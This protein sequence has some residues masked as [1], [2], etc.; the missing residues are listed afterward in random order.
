MV[1]FKATK[2]KPLNRS[3]NNQGCF[4]M[5][6]DQMIENLSMLGTFV[7]S[8]LN[9]EKHP[10]FTE[11]EKNNPWFILPFI[12]NALKNILSYL[13]SE[14]LNSW[15]QHYNFSQNPRRIG[16]VLAGNIPLVGLHD[17]ICVLCSG[18][19]AILQISH[20]DRIL[21]PFLINKLTEINPSFGRRIQLSEIDHNIDAVVATGSDNTARYFQHRYKNIP[22]I[23][24]KNR[25]AAAIIQGNENREELESLAD[26]IFLYFGLGCRNVSKIYIPENYDMESALYF[27]KNY[28]WLINHKKYKHNYLNQRALMKIAGSTYYDNHFCLLTNSIQMV[29]PVS[30][31]YFQ[32]YRS[33][34]VL[35]GYIDSNTDKIQCITG[36][37]NI[38]KHRR[39]IPFG[40]AQNPELWDYADQI[41]IMKF[42]EKL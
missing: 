24:R 37:P 27:F 41:D 33:V 3:L 28:H 29:S 42:F 2:V 11:T 25:I 12:K 6:K 31:L 15:L 39:V 4:F 9:L 7:R 36:H 22:G 20:Q 26:D 10:V 1:N 8:M 18:N 32:H 21:L 19:I 35:S 17:L 13:D 30:V 40:K 38:L 34:E 5:K 16:L 23:I 14:K